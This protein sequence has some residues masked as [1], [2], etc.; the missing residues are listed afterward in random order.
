[1][2]TRQISRIVK[3]EFEN[4]STSSSAK[5]DKTDIFTNHMFRK[6]LQRLIWQYNSKNEVFTLDDLLANS[7]EN[8]EFKGGRTTLF[9]ILKSMGY[10]YKMVNGRKILCELKHGVKAKIAF[11]RKFL[12]FQN[13]S[14][15]FTFVYLDHRLL[16]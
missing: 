5:R 7:R 14:E 12:Q 15:N 6:D 4:L 3:E 10:K 1:V 11:L 2:S 16:I 13:S 8:L 9:K